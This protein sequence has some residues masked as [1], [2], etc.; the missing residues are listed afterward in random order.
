MFWTERE[1]RLRRQFEEHFAAEMKT[2]LYAEN[3][4]WSFIQVE[5]PQ[6]TPRA[7]IN[8][9]YTNDNI[10]VQENPIDKCL[11]E[12]FFEWIRSTNASQII[13]RLSKCKFDTP[14]LLE[15]LPDYVSD[16]KGKLESDGDE[17]EAHRPWVEQ[18]FELWL[19]CY[20]KNPTSLVLR[21]ETTPSSYVY[22]QHLLNSHSGVKPPFVVWQTGKS[23]RREQDQVTKNMRLKEFYQQEFQCIYTADTMNDYHTAVL[24]PVR[25]M[26]GEMIGVP[27]KIVE[28][29][30]LPSYS[31]TTMDVEAWCV[32]PKMDNGTDALEP[33]E[34]ARG[35]SGADEIPSQP[36]GYGRWMEICSISRRTD[37]PQK[38][39]FQTKK[40]IVEKDL[41]VLE[42]AIGLDRCVYC[43]GQRN[44]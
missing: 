26:L 7:N 3:P 4:A 13:N 39:K 16:L 30:R 6:L 35:G 1:I 23:F 20:N 9:N 25:K 41:L 31:E 44:N 37:F 12:E 10:W 2:I 11:L 17:Y 22:A 40:K 27:T 38:A 24:E 5:G 15:A 34:I 43:F 14:E 32:D 42:I 36:L 28:S 33:F 19:D 21:P 18:V 8:P 29:D